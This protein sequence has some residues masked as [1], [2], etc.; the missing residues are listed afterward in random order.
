VTPI[1]PLCPFLFLLP[2]YVGY[3]ALASAYS[4]PADL[5]ITDGRVA[6]AWTVESESESRV[7]MNG[8]DGMLEAAALGGTTETDPGHQ[9][10]AG[11]A[12]G[13]VV[14]GAR[15]EGFGLFL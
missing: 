12:F 2:R 15:C 10:Q 1:R 14:T 13:C 6:T 8:A 5:V 11:G 4:E 7:N 3:A 9:T